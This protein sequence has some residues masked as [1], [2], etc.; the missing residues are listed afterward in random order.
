MNHRAPEP[1]QFSVALEHDVSR[2]QHHRIAESP[3]GLQH[4]VGLGADGGLRSW[5]P[6]LGGE[7]QQGD[8]AQAALDDLR[9]RKAQLHMGLNLLAAP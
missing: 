3:R 7:L 4:G 6:G 1:S 9:R 8:L 5:D 2:L